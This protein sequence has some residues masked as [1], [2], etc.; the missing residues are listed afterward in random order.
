M[1]AGYRASAHAAEAQQKLSSYPISLPLQYELMAGRDG[2]KSGAGRTI[3]ISRAAVVFKAENV[4]PIGGVV[5]LRISWPIQLQ[6]KVALIFEVHGKIG[7]AQGTEIVVEM[8]RHEFR[9]RPPRGPLLFQNEGETCSPDPVPRLTSH[10][11]KIFFAG[12]LLIVSPVVTWHVFDFYSI[13]FLM[14]TGLV[15][16]IGALVWLAVA[17]R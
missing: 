12:L 7:C 9:V 17:G 15:G 1:P 13:L 10:N 14:G 4:L 3:H 8:L 16:A 5:R 2:L 6:S 11:D